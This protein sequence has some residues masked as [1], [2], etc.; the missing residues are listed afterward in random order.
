MRIW[1]LGFA[2][3]L[4]AAF[5]VRFGSGEQARTERI[6]GRKQKDFIFFDLHDLV[7][8]GFLPFFDFEFHFA[9][10]NFYLGFDHL[11]FRF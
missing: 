4:V 6:S 2:G 3:F 9:A 11:K 1:K 5:V 10:S 7:V 8:L